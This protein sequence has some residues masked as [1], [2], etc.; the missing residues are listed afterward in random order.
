MKKKNHVKA[1]GNYI[2]ILNK[3]SESVHVDVEHMEMGINIDFWKATVA[4]GIEVSYQPA[5]QYLHYTI[6]FFRIENGVKGTLIAKYQYAC[7]KNGSVTVTISGTPS[8]PTI[9]HSS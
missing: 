6:A 4:P 1:K 5:I 2:H 9:G 3:M 8:S 7:C